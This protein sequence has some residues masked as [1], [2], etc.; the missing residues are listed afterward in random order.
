MTIETK[1]R[2]DIYTEMNGNAI[3]D[4]YVDSRSTAYIKT[5]RFYWN[6]FLQRMGLDESILGQDDKIIHNV[7]DNYITYL[8]ENNLKSIRPQ[9]AS[10]KFVL[11]DTDH[12]INWRK[13]MKRIPKPQEKAGGEIWTDEDLR[14][15]VINCNTP[16]DRALVFFLISTG[17]RIGI[18]ESLKLKDIFDY[19]K[20]CKLVRITRQKGRS[21]KQTNFLTPEASRYFDEYFVWRK[22]RGDPCNS[23]SPAFAHAQNPYGNLGKAGIYK[24][25]YRIEGPLTG[26]KKIKLEPENWGHYNIQVTHGFRK[27]HNTTIK[28]IDGINSH[29]FEQMFSHTPQGIALDSVY[30][31]PVDKVLFKEFEKYIPFLT[32][33]KSESLTL[34]NKRQESMIQQL[35]SANSKIDEFTSIVKEVQDSYEFIKR[36]P[37]FGCDEI[38]PDIS[39]ILNYKRPTK[40]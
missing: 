9:F 17:C 16:R 29:L 31:K 23:E 24:I 14:K 21:G 18:F 10:V 4:R 38:S 25:L 30:N 36:S 27:W 26:T 2:H 12:I 22:K 35:E 1:S 32:L 5:T 33:D 13:L 8:L 7:L 28:A 40:K 3:I 39:R 6:K 11:E 15:I 19:E 34:K 20:G 37:L